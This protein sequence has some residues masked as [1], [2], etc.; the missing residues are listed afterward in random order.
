MNP[1]LEQLGLA[2]PQ[3]Q[4]GGY[5][6]SV[7]VYTCVGAHMSLYQLLDFAFCVF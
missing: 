5:N 1:Q 6:P 7:C 2:L 4:W 3:Q